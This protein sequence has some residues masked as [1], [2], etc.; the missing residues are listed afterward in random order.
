MLAARALGLDC[1][2]M[3]GFDN[4]RVDEEFFPAGKCEE[5]EQASQKVTLNQTFYATSV[6]ATVRNFLPGI[7]V[8]NSPR[9]ARCCEW[10]R[11][12]IMFRSAVGTDASFC[13]RSSVSI[14]STQSVCWRSAVKEI[15]NDPELETDL[16]GPCYAE[17]AEGGLQL[18]L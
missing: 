6:T 1:G 17:A 13:L 11:W 8:W 14:P 5:C 18:L 7:P 2:P 15:S 10:A 9:R 12:T 3:S 4:A 16:C